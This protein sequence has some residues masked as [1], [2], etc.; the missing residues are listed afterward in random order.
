MGHTEREADIYWT[1]SHINNWEG[2]PQSHIPIFQHTMRKQ[3]DI[4]GKTHWVE[5]PNIPWEEKT[6]CHPAPSC[7]ASRH[8]ATIHSASDIKL[9][10]R[11]REQIHNNEL[12]VIIKVAAACRHL[13]GCELFGLI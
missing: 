3:E 12:A 7:G 11:D 1:S 5:K 13:E 2:L 6:N 10:T 4:R 9:P 8:T